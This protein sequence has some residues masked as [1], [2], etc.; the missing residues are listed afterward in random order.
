MKYMRQS[1]KEGSDIIKNA[2]MRCIFLLKKKTLKNQLNSAGCILKME[3]I[4]PRI[5]TITM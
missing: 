4:K 1:T 2:R 5:D 3:H